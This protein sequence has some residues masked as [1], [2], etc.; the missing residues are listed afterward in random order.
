M[1]TICKKSYPQFG[2]FKDEIYDVYFDWED[3]DTK[4]WFKDKHLCT[5]V[6]MDPNLFVFS[7]REG[8][9]YFYTPDEIY[10]LRKRKLNELGS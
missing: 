9:I 4:D 3:P 2:I 7:K 6:K 10:K 5:L 8:P 1:K